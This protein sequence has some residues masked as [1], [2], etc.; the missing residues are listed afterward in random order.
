MVKAAEKVQERAPPH[1]ASRWRPAFETSWSPTGSITS[2]AAGQ[3]LPW[4]RFAEKAYGEGL[5]A[6]MEPGLEATEYFTPAAAVYPFGAH[7]AVVEVDRDTGRV[8][9]AST[10]RWTTA[11]CASAAPGGGQVHGRHRQG[12]AQSL[13]E[14]RGL[15]RGEPVVTGTLMDL[16]GPARGGPAFFKTDQTVTPRRQPVGAKG[17]GEAATSARRPRWSTRWWT[18]EAVRRAP[19]RHAP[20]PERVAGDAE[21]SRAFARPGPS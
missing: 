2:R 1:R 14:E 7:V 18:R 4:P 5:L 21:G 20:P 15:Q 10:L 11:A 8:T 16:R 6:G 17:I 19:P 9:C 12:V 13:L 3:R